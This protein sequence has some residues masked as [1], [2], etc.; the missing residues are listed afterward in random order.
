MAGRGAGPA[1]GVEAQDAG[2]VAVSGD[3]GGGARPGGLAGSGEV[4]LNMSNKSCAFIGTYRSSVDADNRIVV[5]SAFRRALSPGAQNTLVVARGYGGCLTVYPLDRWR[6]LM[7]ELRARFEAS[8]R[9]MRNRVR[10]VISQASD[11]SLSSKGRIR[12]PRKLL[13]RAR[14]E[15]E[16][17]IVGVLDSFELWEP[18]RYDEYMATMIDSGEVALLLASEE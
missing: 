16:V 3:A 5:P 15:R 4:A 7:A 6:E 9:H 11:V 2:R 17:L 18:T 13:N 1:A 8:E 10:A 14:I 12:I